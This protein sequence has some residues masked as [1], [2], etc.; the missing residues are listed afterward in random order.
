MTDETHDKA[1]QSWVA[2]ANGHPEFPLQNLP[3]GVFSP[4]GR[5]APDAAP[6]GGIAI[7]DMIFDLRAAHHAGLFSADAAT[8][9]RAASG[10]SLNPLMAL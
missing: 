4:P 5:T 1:R 9:A 3:F 10:V 8:A 7:G 6:R 2:S